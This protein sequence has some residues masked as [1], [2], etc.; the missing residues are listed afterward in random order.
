MKKIIPNDATLI[1]DS[2]KQVFSG[3]LFDVYQWQ[4]R[5]FDGSET[6][7]EMLRRADTVIANCIVGDKI[8]VLEDEQPHHGVRTS[9]PGG[10]V[11][12]ADS[13]IYTAA[14]REVLEETG[15]TFKDWKLIHVAQPFSK[16]EW[17]IYE[18]VAWNPL[19]KDSPHFDP[20]E[21]ITVNKFDFNEVRAL[22]LDPSNS[23]GESIEYYQR[24]QDVQGLINLSEYV[25]KEIDR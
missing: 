13:D 11:D 1:P 10:R 16:V 2:A 8:L 20:G 5:L 7:F 19:K 18:F 14:K 17:F 24:M 23:L 12:E 15:Y 3:I 6:T 4:Q 25:G 22:V 21:R 9:F